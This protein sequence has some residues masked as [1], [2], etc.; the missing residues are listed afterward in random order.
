MLF[1]FHG[2][3]EQRLFEA[4]AAWKLTAFGATVANTENIVE[5][6]FMG[7]PPTCNCG[8]VNIQLLEARLSGFRATSAAV[9]LFTAY[10]AS[11]RFWVEPDHLRCN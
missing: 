11:V 10:G 6:G 4:R 2:R 7:W 3:R 8:G 5:T 9:F 1:P